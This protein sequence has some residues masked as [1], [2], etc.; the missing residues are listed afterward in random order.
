MID[1]ASHLG[2]SYEAKRASNK[3]YRCAHFYSTAEILELLEQMGFSPFQICQTIFQDPRE[4]NVPEPVKEGYGEGGF[5]AI[6][7]KKA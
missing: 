7:A 6:S 2:R 3:F 5:V 1:R 4:I